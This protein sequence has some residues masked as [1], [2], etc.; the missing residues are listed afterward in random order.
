MENIANNIDKLELIDSLYKK[1]LKNYFAYK[2]GAQYADDFYQDI[3]I[4]VL[5]SKKPVPKNKI[6]QWIFVIAHNE[7]VSYLRLSSTEINRRTMNESDLDQYY[8]EEYNPSR[9]L[10]AIDTSNHYHDRLNTLNHK[11]RTTYFLYKVRGFN[12]TQI[13]KIIGV[14]VSAIEKHM[15]DAYKEL[16]E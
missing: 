1:E 6:R 14:S 5:N 12:Q 3:C 4:K 13:S 15:M 8:T 9:I 16:R 10:Q 2:L 7:I 11:I